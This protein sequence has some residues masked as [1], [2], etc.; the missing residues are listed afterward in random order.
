MWALGPAGAPGRSWRDSFG[1]QGRAWSTEEGSRISAIHEDVGSVRESSMYVGSTKMLKDM[2]DEL[3]ADDDVLQAQGR[4]AG[5]VAED[6]EGEGEEDQW[7][8]AWE[9]YVH[10]DGEESALSVDLHSTSPEKQMGHPHEVRFGQTFAWLVVG[11]RQ[12]AASVLP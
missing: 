3:A 10:S 2:V 7:V 6:V 11:R 9:T 5:I 12:A 4:P 1:S 8:S